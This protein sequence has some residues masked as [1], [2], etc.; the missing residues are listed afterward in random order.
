V[1]K[2]DTAAICEIYNHYVE[3]G[4]ISF[5]TES[6]NEPEMGSRIQTISSTYPYLVYEE[7]GK[8]QA[9]AYANLWKTRAAYKHSLET[10]VYA[11]P[12]ILEKGVGR[13]LY[14]ALFDALDKNSVHTLMAVIALPNEASVRFHE[15]MGYVKAGYF[16]E[17]GSKFG[18]WIDVGYWQK[19]L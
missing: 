15:K 10:T 3:T 1:T 16:K 12:D 4:F 8:V 19:M 13:T 9:F 5:E 2:A 11:S 14:Q 6:V 18:N 7:Q 17:V